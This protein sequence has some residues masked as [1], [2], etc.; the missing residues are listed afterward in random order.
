M[1]TESFYPDGIGGAHSYVYNLGKSL[2]KKGHNVYIITIK[3]RKDMPDEETIEGMKV[4]RYDSV[5]SGCLIY[6]R[7]FL[8]SVMNAHR[9]FNNVVKKVKVDIINCHSPLP[10]FGV[11]L[12]FKH[13][14]MY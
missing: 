10:A 9:L 7:R 12:F 13:R 14:N 2:I 3:M 5:V 6:I 8:L 11:N 4:F 1:I